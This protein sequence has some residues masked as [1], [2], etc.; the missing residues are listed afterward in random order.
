M[1]LQ[2]ETATTQMLGSAH[3]GITTQLTRT[4]WSRC[5]CMSCI[6][7]QP[8]MV[9]SCPVGWDAY[10]DWVMHPVGRC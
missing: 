8:V 9:C 10:I 4:S 2:V 3:S 1:M 5:M 6:D 7:V